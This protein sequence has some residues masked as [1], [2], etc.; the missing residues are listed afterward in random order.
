MLQY[1]RKT[2][3]TRIS[4]SPT[5]TAQ[6]QC[7]YI[8]T[9]IIPAS[10]V[11]RFTYSPESPRIGETVTFDASESFDPEGTIVEYAWDF[12]GM[13][14]TDMIVN[15]TY[16]AE[17]TFTITLTVTDDDGLTDTATADITV[18]HRVLA[19]KLSGEFDYLFMENVKIRVAT[20]VTDAET[21]EPISNADVT[22]EIYDPDG[23]LWVSA[24]MVERLPARGIYEWKSAKTIRQLMSHRQLRKGIYLVH[25]QASYYGGPTATDILEFHI[26]P[27]QEQLI[28]LKT[29]L[30]VTMIGIVGLIASVWYIDHRRL[31]RRLYELEE[32]KD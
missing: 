23:E 1:S 10:P 22:M 12:D 28:E 13:S 5:A 32:T 16:S 30:L 3:T 11:A 21:M 20:L 24:N 2:T 15:Y 29:M 27:P 7:K 25:V 19:V 17:G 9:H 14:A 31:S 6:K 8:G 18:I 26:D 4:I